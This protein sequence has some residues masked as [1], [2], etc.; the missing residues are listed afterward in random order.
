MDN[1]FY[2]GAFALVLSQTAIVNAQFLPDNDL[3]QQ[4]VITEDANITQE[5]FNTIIDETA[6]PFYDYATKLGGTLIVNKLWT[7]KTVNANATQSAFG[8][9]KWTVNMYGGLARR[10]EITQ[11]GFRLVLC[12][13]L[14]HHFG[15]YPFVLQTG[16]FSKIWAADEGQADYFA[17]NTCARMEW[18]A[19]PE[20]NAQFRA[21]ADS[22]AR[23][24]CD[25]VWSTVAEQNLCY[26]ISA[27]GTSLAGLLNTL[28]NEKKA[29]KD[30]KPM[31]TFGT[32]DTTTVKTTN[33]QHPAAQC[34]LDTYLQGSLCVRE[35]D[36][37]NIPGKTSAGGKNSVASESEA[38]LQSCMTF[39]GFDVG[40]R[41]TCW[42]KELH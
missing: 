28:T 15:G 39:D 10:P 18:M 2:I 27:A 8:N 1:R 7:N 35:R 24:K 17:T 4:D 25:T 33:H 34:R 32:P 5:Q 42:F 6:K 37:N 31:P 12:H 14:G 22:V 29:E 19:Q 21:T 23:E 30:K 20:V 26:R 11:D 16:L 38:A 40:V 9:K 41:P 3:D 13:E 36:L